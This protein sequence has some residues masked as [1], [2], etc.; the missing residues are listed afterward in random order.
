MAEAVELK[1]DCEAVAIP[2]GRRHL[3]AKGTHV[4]VVQKRESSF[5]VASLNRAM[6]RIDVQYADALGILDADGVLV[7]QQ[8][9]RLTE[10]LVW[11]TLRT[12]Y[13]PELPVN[14]VELGLIYSCSLVPDQQGENIVKVKMSMTSPGCGMSDVLK[15]EVETK[16]RRLPEVK[17]ATVEVVF[18]PP[19]S[20]SRMSEV[21]RLQL[22][23]G[24][25]SGDDLVQ[26]SPRR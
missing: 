8:E 11:D 18:D 12:V 20:P 5:T 19:W 6:Y 24:I 1:R 23:M 10:Q 17:D 15:S 13:D 16:L 7:N 21:A 2:S 4:T 9:G 3:L 14:V 22:D 26:I 25:N